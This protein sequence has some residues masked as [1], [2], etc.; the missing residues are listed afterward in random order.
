MTDYV[1]TPTPDYVERAAVTRLMRRHGIETYRDLVRRS[2]EDLE[3]FWEAVVEDVGIDFFRPYETLLDATEGPQWPRWFIGG[4]INLAYN[5]VD[6]H[7]ASERAGERALVWEGEDGA[8]RTLTYADLGDAVK[9]AANGLAE[10]GI[11][12]GDAVGVYMPMV[13]EA[14]VAMYACAE[15]GAI[16]LPIF[17]G[18]G[19]PAIATRLQDAGAKALVTA[20][21][22]Y[23]RGSKVPMKATADEAVAAS[24]TVE[25]VVVFRRFPGDE[26]TLTERDVEWE[27]L[28]GRQS[29]DRAA[30]ELD[31]E[32]PFMIAYTSGTT[33]K[34]KGSVHVHGGFLVKI[35]SE[36]AYQFDVSP[37]EV[38]YW[39]TD[40]GWIMG[41]FEMVGGHANGAC[42]FMYEGAPNHPDAGRLW[43]M[44]ERH[45]VTVLGISPTLVRALM[46]SGEEPVKRADLSRL[47][48]L[49]STGEPWNPEP[50]RWFSDVVGG[51][52]CPIINISGGTEIGACFLGQAPVIPTKACSLGAPWLGMAIDVFG[53]DGKPVRGE[54]G[55]LVCTKPWPAQTRGFWKNPQRYLDAYW[56][57]WQ[58]V[59]V[60]GDWASVDEDGYWFLHGRSDDTLNIAGK[61]IGPAEFESAAVDH[62]AVVECAAVGVPDAV[63]GE[64]VW[65]FCILRP[66][67]DPTEELAAE[68]K[69]TIANEL[70]KAFA[71][72]AV[73]FV[74]ELPKTRSAKILRRAIRAQVLG[75]DPGDLSSL[76]NPSALEAV[77][78]SLA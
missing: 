63:K 75:E 54:V 15:L 32:T 18:F 39:V 1:W 46:P 7:A 52:R 74:E 71:P 16:Y 40:M 70:G 51:G 31:P 10:L 24:P 12:Q 19:A 66:E 28:C 13:P 59:W 44:C 49:G 57:R 14:V 34:P 67:V 26:L 38:L 29:A 72:A 69:A 3:W 68:V 17:S 2:S 25:N 37:G 5:C 4:R 45:G 55:E 23:R 30:A 65:C 61:R 56:S 20:D 36:A 8:V 35:A 43:Q 27:E 22:F 48:L 6:R 64:A 58:D 62:P 21:A 77:K 33:G 73:R 78:K 42:V 41:P 53:P 76:E 47:R 11:G 9:R 60:H 50:Y